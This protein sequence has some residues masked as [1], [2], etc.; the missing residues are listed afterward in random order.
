MRGAANAVPASMN[1]AT[2]VSTAMRRSLRDRDIGLSF[3]SGS[4][5]IYTLGTDSER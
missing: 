5:L 3:G 1:E 2:T 4:E